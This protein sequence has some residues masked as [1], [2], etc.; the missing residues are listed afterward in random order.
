[1]SEQR[2]LIVRD[3]FLWQERNGIPYPKSFEW[4][5][6][7]TSWRDFITEQRKVAWVDCAEAKDKRIMELD[8]ER[9]GFL[10]ETKRQGWCIKDIKKENTELREC[11]GDII[12]FHK[13]VKLKGEWETLDK[14]IE[15]AQ[16]LLKAL[17][18]NAS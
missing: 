17:G 15:E 4:C 5:N 18:K 7:K 13:L 1:M 2:D 14:L 12:N 8:E 9:L 6:D 3:F 11:L 10:A 16:R